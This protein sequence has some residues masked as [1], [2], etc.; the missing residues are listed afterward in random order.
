MKDR[1][2]NGRMC[3]KEP[4][5]LRSGR[6]QSRQVAGRARGAG[7]PAPGLAEGRAHCGANRVGACCGEGQGAEQAHLAGEEGR[8]SRSPMDQKT[9]NNRRG[10]RS[11]GSRNVYT[12]MTTVLPPSHTYTTYSHS[13][14]CCLPDSLVMVRNNAPSWAHAQ[15]RIMTSEL[16]REP[17][18]QS[19]R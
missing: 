17:L 12:T 15:H 6:L 14:C 16:A 3:C 5:M 9:Y 18:R 1:V 19:A 7:L 10:S 11:G 2:S 4:L 8:S 13:I